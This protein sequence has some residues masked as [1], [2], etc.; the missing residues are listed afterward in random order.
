MNYKSIPY[1]NI[2]TQVKKI[3][4]VNNNL[5][6]VFKQE[7][8]RKDRIKAVQNKII[9]VVQFDK[10]KTSKTI[11]ENYWYN[12]ME[13]IKEKYKGEQ[14]RIE[15]IS[16][17]LDQILNGKKPTYEDFSKDNRNAKTKKINLYE[18]ITLVQEELEIIKE[19]ETY[20]DDLLQYETQ[21]LLEISEEIESYSEHL[22]ETNKKEIEKLD[23]E[24]MRYIKFAKKDKQRKEEIKKE[25]ILFIKRYGETIQLVNEYNQTINICQSYIKRLDEKIEITEF[26]QNNKHVFSQKEEKQIKV[27]TKYI[28]S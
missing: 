19:E 1:D 23:E 4:E 26:Y 25:N 7:A 20:L 18:L 2:S 22:T 17:A 27:I 3:K 5:K 6:R 28:N 12:Q 14:K 10:D 9:Q 21:Q 11:N 24:F 15:T 13:F 16:I 8:N